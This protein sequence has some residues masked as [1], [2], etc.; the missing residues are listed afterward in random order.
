MGFRV[1]EARSDV[2]AYDG[3]YQYALVD[4][5]DLKTMFQTESY[6]P[7]FHDSRS[8]PIVRS[9]SVS[10]LKIQISQIVL[11]FESYSL[12]R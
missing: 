12:S 3:Q 2:R 10:A 6:R 8:K 5:S 1:V 7:Y 9:A 4:L 11:C